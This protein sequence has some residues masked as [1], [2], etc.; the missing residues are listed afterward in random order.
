MSVCTGLV[1]PELHIQMPTLFRYVLLPHRYGTVKEGKKGKIT[2][3]FKMVM[4]QLHDSYT[5]CSSQLPKGE[6]ERPCLL[7]TGS[8][9]LLTT[10]CLSRADNCLGFG[11]VLFSYAWPLSAH[12]VSWCAHLYPLH[13]V[14]GTYLLCLSY[15][16]VHRTGALC[17][18]NCCGFGNFFL[19]HGSLK[20]F[21]KYLI[22]FSCPSSSFL[23]WMWHLCEYRLGSGV[24]VS[25]SCHRE[26]LCVC[27]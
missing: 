4:T 1:L 12:S 22:H 27:H 6:F 15:R 17:G 16:S 13:K 25:H 9:Q 7:A 18:H 3:S 20:G 26:L 14:E 8:W 5:P 21:A 10:S 19:S 23:W 11:Q 2:P 24:S